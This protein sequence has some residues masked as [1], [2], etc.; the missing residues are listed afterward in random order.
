LIGLAARVSASSV[1]YLTHRASK[2]NESFGIHLGALRISVPSLTKALTAMETSPSFRR[3][4]SLL[5]QI[6]RRVVARPA[7]SASGQALGVRSAYRVPPGS[8]PMRSEAPARSLGSSKPRASVPP[9][10][11]VAAGV[12]DRAKTM[13]SLDEVRADLARLRASSRERHAPVPIK[14]QTTF[15]ATVFA[16]FTEAAT[17]GKSDPPQ[18]YSRTVYLPLSASKSQSR[19]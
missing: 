10:P 18:D 19:K 8:A 17:T 1:R 3:L 7:K 4:L 15:D 6:G 2:T 5:A 9:A 11:A 14:R 16:N 13:R 12:R